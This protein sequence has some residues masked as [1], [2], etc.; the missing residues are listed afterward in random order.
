MQV[1][2]D[3]ILIGDR[4]RKRVFPG[5][6][7]SYM[8]PDVVEIS[9]PMSWS[10]KSKSLKQKEVIIGALNFSLYCLIGTFDDF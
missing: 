9:P 8:D 7:S 6:S 10:S 1:C 2:I 3:S 5:S 4:C